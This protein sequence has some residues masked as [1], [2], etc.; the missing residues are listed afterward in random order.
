MDPQRP[1]AFNHKFVEYS[2][3]SQTDQSSRLP[4]ELDPAFQ[5]P[6]GDFWGSEHSDTPDL[7]QDRSHLLP[8]TFSSESGSDE[9]D[10]EAEAD[11]DSQ[12]PVAE[13][14]KASHSRPGML[15]AG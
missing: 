11:S 3:A 13:A 7:K 4:P 1:Q 10:A 8:P 9:D 5:Q 6:L 15:G 12:S 2:D 14:A